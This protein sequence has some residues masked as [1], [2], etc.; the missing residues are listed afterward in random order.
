MPFEG[1][2]EIIVR[3][4]RGYTFLSVMQINLITISFAKYASW[5]LDF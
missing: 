2:N 1:L 4:M 5:K 3:F